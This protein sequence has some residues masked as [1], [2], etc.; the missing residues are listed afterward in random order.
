MLRCDVF[1]PAGD[2]QMYMPPYAVLVDRRKESIVITIRGTMSLKVCC[3]FK[4]VV[5]HCWYKVWIK[6]MLFNDVP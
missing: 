1:F 3:A 5:S 6:E 4:S 2:L